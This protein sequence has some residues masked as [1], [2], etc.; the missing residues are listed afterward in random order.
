MLI[1]TDHGEERMRKRCGLKK[2][3]AERL[4]KIAF[5]KGIT[6][7]ETTGELHSYLK[8][9]QRYNGQANNIRVYGDKIYIFCNEYLV[10]VLNT[11]REYQNKVNAIMSQRKN[12]NV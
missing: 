2:K 8:A 6:L 4:A 11:P 10:T 3:A 1:V 12:Q 5:E 9:Q 7:E